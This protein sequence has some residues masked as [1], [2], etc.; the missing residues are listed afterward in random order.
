MSKLFHSDKMPRSTW[1]GIGLLVAV[2]FFVSMSLLNISVKEKLADETVKAMLTAPIQNEKINRKKIVI[3]KITKRNFNSEA[4]KMI[5]RDGLFYEI[6]YKKNRKFSNAEL[7]CLAQNIYYEAGV[8]D[9]IGK[10]A[11]AQVTINR[12]K[13]SRFAN[14]VCK[15]VYSKSYYKIEKGRRVAASKSDSSVRVSCAF[16]WV[17][18]NK[19]A[20]HGE[21]WAKSQ[22]IARLVLHGRV[23]LTAVRSALFYYASYI[24]QPYWV[25]PSA[26][27]IEIGQHIFYSDCKRT[28]K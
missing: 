28:V 10:F 8:E 4:E 6:H 23:G 25:D 7:H 18:Q 26:K 11:V 24:K 21:M 13:D 20:P 9:D 17:C 22:E 16:T 15:V 5:A 19:P 12:V 2:A 1:L 3:K 14:T 27:I